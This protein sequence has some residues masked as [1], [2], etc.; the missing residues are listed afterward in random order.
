M[1]KQLEDHEF[2]IRLAAEKR[3]CMHT[4]E[5]LVR[6]HRNSG[7]HLTDHRLS[8]LVNQLRVVK[9]HRA[10][11]DSTFGAGGARAAK[12]KYIRREGIRRG[13]LVGRLI[14]GCGCMVGA[15][16]EPLWTLFTSRRLLEVPYSDYHQ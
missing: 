9:K 14:Y 10:L 12:S 11:Y 3:T 5:T 2:F 7:D 13:G 15:A 1:P 16:Y 6:L 4:S 8:F